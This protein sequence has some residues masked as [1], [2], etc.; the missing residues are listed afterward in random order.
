M[1]KVRNKEQ[2]MGRKI[3]KMGKHKYLGVKKVEGITI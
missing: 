2:A 1:K 3:S